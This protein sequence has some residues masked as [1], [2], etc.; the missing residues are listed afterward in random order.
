MLLTITR[1][2]IFPIRL[3]LHEPFVVSYA[4]QEDIPTVL[5]RITAQ[6][7]QTGWGE[8]TPDPNVTGE[9]WHSTIAVLE[10]DLAPAVIGLDA[11]DR[12]GIVRAMDARHRAGNGCPGRCGS[13]G[14]SGDRYRRP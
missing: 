11:L 4:T 12:E 14:Q 2:E 1:V 7:G 5:V 8:A 6:D 3:A 10:H 13:G 9:T